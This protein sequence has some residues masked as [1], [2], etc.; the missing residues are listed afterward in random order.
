MF[1]VS[2]PCDPRNMSVRD[3]SNFNPLELTL[4]KLLAVL[5]SLMAF[6]LAHAAEIPD[7]P[8]PEPNYVGII[9][10][11]VLMVGGG[12]WFMWRIMRN[13]GDGDKK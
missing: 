2:V 13:K 3:A 9:V 5:T 7:A 11:L 1:G 4:T 6:G 12:V 10:F 8:I